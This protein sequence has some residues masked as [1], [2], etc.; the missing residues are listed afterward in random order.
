MHFFLHEIC[1]FLVFKTFKKIPFIFYI[2]PGPSFYALPDFWGIKI[3]KI[4]RVFNLAYIIKLRCIFIV[5]IDFSIFWSILYKQ[6]KNKNSRLANNRSPS[7]KFGKKNDERGMSISFRVVGFKSAR[8]WPFF[9]PRFDYL[10]APEY[11][12]K[13]IFQFFQC[14]NEMGTGG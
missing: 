10:K 6:S 12:Q 1:V 2:T 8:K 5:F 4:L 9:A 3:L 14:V 11:G 7:G 13:V